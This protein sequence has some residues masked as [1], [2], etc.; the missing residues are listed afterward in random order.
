VH[1]SSGTCYLFKKKKALNP[2]CRKVK[3]TFH[4]PHTFSGSC[5]VFI[6]SKEIKEKVPELLQ[7]VSISYYVTSLNILQYFFRKTQTMKMKLF[8][9][10]EDKAL[11]PLFYLHD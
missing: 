11:K 10:K 1:I 5:T 7:Y 2:S 8:R 4:A 9:K 3:N 6:I